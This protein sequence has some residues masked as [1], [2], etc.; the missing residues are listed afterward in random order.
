P[1]PQL[2]RDAPVGRLLERGNR[3]PVLG[4]GVVADAALFQCR[5]RR[6][7][8]LFHRTPPLQGDERLDARVAALARAHRM[9]VRLA[10]LDETALVGPCDEACSRLLL[11]ET[12][13][14]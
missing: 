1:P 11:R 5:D 13:E 2:A 7:C 3:E 9:P 4:L 8:G 6:R 14:V 12:G 10:L